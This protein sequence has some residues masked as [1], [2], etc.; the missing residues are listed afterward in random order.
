MEEV[1]TD[2]NTSVNKT[3]GKSPFEA[4]YG[5]KHHFVDGDVRVR[6]G[7]DFVRTHCQFSW[8]KSAL[9]KQRYDPTALKQIKKK[10][11]NALVWIQYKWVKLVRLLQYT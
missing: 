5:F 2:I 4:L 10:F 1:E 9:L 8:K 7:E 11:F 3:L 6:V